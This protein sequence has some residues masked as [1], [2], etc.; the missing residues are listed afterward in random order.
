MGM[1]ALQSPKSLSASS[2]TLIDDLRREF[3]NQT[4]TDVILVAK[5]ITSNRRPFKQKN[6]A[7]PNRIIIYFTEFLIL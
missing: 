7:I 1:K 5:G 4:F 2:P 3:H 6:C